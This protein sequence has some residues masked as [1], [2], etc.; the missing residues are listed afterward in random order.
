MANST[1]LNNAISH[2]FFPQELTFDWVDSVRMLLDWG[3][4][5]HIYIIAHTNSPPW[6]IRKQVYKLKNHT[7]YLLLLRLGKVA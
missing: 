4:P 6:S 5:H 2:H 1:R 3:C 7:G